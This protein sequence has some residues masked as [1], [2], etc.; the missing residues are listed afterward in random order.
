MIATSGNEIKLW[1][2][3][4]YQ[5][6]NEFAFGKTVNSF[7]VKPDLSSIACIVNKDILSLI[8]IDS[9]T[10]QTLLPSDANSK[11]CTFD[12]VNRHLAVGT[13][14]GT[15][16]IYDLKLVSLKKKSTKVHNCEITT[17]C[18]SK[19]D[20]YLATGNVNG[21]IVIFSPDTGIL[22]KPLTLPNKTSTVTCL[23]YSKH[24][25]AA[26]YDDGTTVCWDTIKEKPHCI[27]NNHTSPCTSVLISQLN[28]IL[29]I[30]TSLDTTYACYDTDSKKF[31]KSTCVSVGITSMDFHKNG[32]TLALGASNGHVFI[33]DLRSKNDEPIYSFKAHDTPVYSLKFIDKSSA[34][35]HSQQTLSETHLSRTKLDE[36]L[37]IRKSNSSNDANNFSMGQP[38]VTLMPKSTSQMS[39][40]SYNSSNGTAKTNSNPESMQFST[41]IF[42][43]DVM[44]KTDP[45]AS[46]QVNSTAISNNTTMATS[47]QNGGLNG[48]G[49]IVANSAA[50]I[51]HRSHQGTFNDSTPINAKT[52]SVIPNKGKNMLPNFK[53][54]IF[55]PLQTDT[56]PTMNGDKK[57]NGFGS[58]PIYKQSPIP[59]NS[60]MPNELNSIQTENAKLTST[61]N[62]DYNNDVSMSSVHGETPLKM[63]REEFNAKTKDTNDQSH[64]FTL[65]STVAGI[66]NHAHNLPVEQIKELIKDSIDD[67][68]DDLMSESFRFKAELFKEFMILKNDIQTALKACSLNE[69]LVNEVVRLRDENK[70]LKKL[71]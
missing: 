25:L 9:Q 27:F 69:A 58:N 51:L 53:S 42:S 16:D 24:N 12:S 28:G 20:R 14:F 64:S 40:N 68:R 6:I 45:Y 1:N 44:M 33:Y 56:P 43:P 48:S 21:A 61:A 15:I 31:I 5:F 38:Q 55:S 36:T 63:S 59:N 3:E 46:T 35:V 60:V 26:S 47:S 23:C 17:I 32:F 50:F 70:R 41:N 62:N 37:Q 54:D 7:A 8:N 66:E 30:S 13:L 11:C 2:S 29:M 65:N 34:N 49:T 71:F 19:N 57:A 22:K 52:I 39:F 67:L 4:N 18:W 10:V